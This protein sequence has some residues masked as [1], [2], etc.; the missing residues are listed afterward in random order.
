VA[1]TYQAVQ[2]SGEAIFC[3]GGQVVINNVENIR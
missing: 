3:P 1:G 2:D